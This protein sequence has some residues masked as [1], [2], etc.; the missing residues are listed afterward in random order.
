M[1]RGTWYR[2]HDSLCRPFRRL[3][4]AL[5]AKQRWLTPRA[6][7]RLRDYYTVYNRMCLYLDR[8][9]NTQH[10]D[11]VLIDE[12]FEDH[13]LLQEAFV[14]I[15]LAIA[16]KPE[17]RSAQRPLWEGEQTTS[18]L[19]PS[20]YRAPEPVPSRAAP[21]HD[22]GSNSAP[23][24]EDLTRRY[25]YFCSTIVTIWSNFRQITLPHMH[26][27]TPEDEF[28]LSDTPGNECI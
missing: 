21:Q 15:F 1:R 8:K 25:G 20:I 27:L 24:G 18:G 6:G 22:L 13:T 16:R 10:F 4:A 19:C 12:P 11:S 17:L 3:H 5:L 9:K 26:I 23:G 28:P 2:I 7:E 14:T